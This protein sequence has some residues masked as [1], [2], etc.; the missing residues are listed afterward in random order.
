MPARSP[1]P[2]PSMLSLGHGNETESKRHPKSK[3]RGERFQVCGGTPRKGEVL[4]L[5]RTKKHPNQ[6]QVAGRLRCM[7]CELTYVI[8]SSSTPSP[9]GFQLLA[10]MT[11]FAGGQE[12]ARAAGEERGTLEREDELMK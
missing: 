8:F 2:V 1:P 4:I 9:S 7:G 11:S 10:S 3:M 5:P 12:S 6:I